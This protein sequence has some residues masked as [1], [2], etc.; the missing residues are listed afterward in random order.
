MP[1]QTPRS[2]YTVSGRV[3]RNAQPTAL[4]LQVRASRFVFQEWSGVIHGLQNIAVDASFDTTLKGPLPQLATDIDLR[5]SGGSVK[6]HLTLD[7][8]V[9]GW[10]GAGTLDVERINLARWLNNAER[11]SDITGRV[12]FDLALELGR[13]F[14]RGVYRF[15]GRHAM[16]MNYAADNLRANGQITESAVL[17]QQAAARAYGAGATVTGGSIGLASPF[18]VS[19]SRND[20]GHRPAQRA[21]NGSDP[22]GRERAD[23]RLRRLR[24]LF[25]SRSSSGRRGFS[26]RRF[27]A[28]Q[29]GSGAVGSIDTQ[30][31]PLRYTG[32][33]DVADA[34][35]GR[36]G[37]GLDVGWLR[38]PKFA[39]TMSGHFRVEGTGTNRATMA[40]TASGRVAQG[41]AVSRNAERR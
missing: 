41:V 18:P 15:D 40:M 6:G 10:R 17:I 8:T 3:I 14:P 21:R 35:L 9:P 36:F 26:R 4:D 12:A 38:E 7:T 19:L 33:G 1:S 24:D 2:A 25:A 28:R 29:I 27:S 34:D 32:E 37:V 22:A 23:L 11:P 39:G 16:Y 5:G 31:Q 30:Q 13:H 20:Y